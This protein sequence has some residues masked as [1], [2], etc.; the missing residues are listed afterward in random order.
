MRKY[1]AIINQPV[2]IIAINGRHQGHNMSGSSLADQVFFRLECS[3]EQSSVV[4]STVNTAYR[5]F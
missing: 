4:N 1:I 3:K 2:I 5:I